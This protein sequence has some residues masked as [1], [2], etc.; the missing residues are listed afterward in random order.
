MSFGW[1]LPAGM[2]IEVTSSSLD[3]TSTS[4]N[5]SMRPEETRGV[6]AAIWTV[7]L[8]I[9]SLQMYSIS[10]WA[11]SVIAQAP[12]RSAYS[13]FRVLGQKFFARRSASGFSRRTLDD[14]TRGFQVDGSRRD[15]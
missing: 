2:R 8:R 3:K 13:Q 14:P 7:G 15:S 12:R 1:T 11:E 6:S 5:E 9:I 4:E 10:S